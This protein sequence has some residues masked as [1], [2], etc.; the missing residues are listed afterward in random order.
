VHSV[1]ELKYR[2]GEDPREA[3]GRDHD[4]EVEKEAFDAPVDGFQH[5][6]G[7]AQTHQAWCSNI[8]AIDS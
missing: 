2:S 7:V 5:G 8:D 3:D 6:S 4:Q 1:R